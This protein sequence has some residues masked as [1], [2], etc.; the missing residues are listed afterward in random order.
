MDAAALLTVPEAA[1]RVSLGRATAY[2]LVQTGDLPSVRIG[3]AVR[4]PAQALD[5]WILAHTNGG[6]APDCP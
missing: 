1:R 2:R 4:V 3:R 6:S 5:A